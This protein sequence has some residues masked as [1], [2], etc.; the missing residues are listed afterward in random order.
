MKNLLCLLFLIPLVSC[1]GVPQK[2]KDAMTVALNNTIWELYLKNDIAVMGL[3]TECHEIKFVKND[4]LRPNA[5]YEGDFRSTFQSED[6]RYFLST[7]TYFDKY[8]NVLKK[9]EAEY[10]IS[11]ILFMCIS[12]TNVYH[13]NKED[14]YYLPEFE[15]IWMIQLLKSKFENI[16]A[17]E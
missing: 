13:L 10:Y 3:N 12:G 14:K 4:S 2:D 6:R 8:M 16:P 9:S 11:E 1:S 7:T 15:N 5:M 17:V